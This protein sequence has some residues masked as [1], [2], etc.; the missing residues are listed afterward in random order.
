MSYSVGLVFLTA[1]VKVDVVT[2]ADLLNA[3]V[4]QRRC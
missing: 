2:A 4:I 3:A 1:V